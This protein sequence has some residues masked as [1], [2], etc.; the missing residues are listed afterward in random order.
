MICLAV[1]LRLHAVPDR[2]WVRA[3]DLAATDPDPVHGASI[4]ALIAAIGGV[5]LTA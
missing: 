5:T 2:S 4:E 1:W 3:G